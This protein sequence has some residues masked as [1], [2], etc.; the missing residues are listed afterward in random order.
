K[1]IPTPLTRKY[2]N[3]L[4]YS[5]PDRSLGIP[6]PT[7]ENSGAIPLTSPTIIRGVT[8]P[9]GQTNSG[10]VAFIPPLIYTQIRMLWIIPK[11]QVISLKNI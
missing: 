1:L 11:H 10:D 7:Q 2:R 4:I 3:Y 6:I 9:P 5:H 8:M